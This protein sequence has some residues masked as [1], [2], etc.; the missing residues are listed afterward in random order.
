MVSAKST[1]RNLVH[2]PDK[3]DV[4]ELLVIAHRFFSVQVAIGLVS[5]LAAAW[6]RSIGL[7][8]LGNVSLPLLGWASTRDANPENFRRIRLCAVYWL[9]GL[10]CSLFRGLSSGSAGALLAAALKLVVFGAQWLVLARLWRMLQDR[11]LLKVEFYLNIVVKNK[12]DV[13]RMQLKERRPHIGGLLGKLAN[14]LVS[15]DR[16]SKK[17]AV[18]LEEMIPARMS[19]RAGV[20]ATAAKQFQRGNLIVMLVTVE[21]VDVRRMVQLKRG[22]A[23][24]GWVDFLMT[25][26]T[27]MPL[28]LRVDLEHVLLAQ[29]ARGLLQRLPEEMTRQMQEVGG[30]EV[31]VEAKSKAEE[32]EFLFAAMKLLDEEGSIVQ[33]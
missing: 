30:M 22:E 9:A 13:I 3:L 11:L 12:Q 14:S 33:G 2:H 6:H 15:D 8:T 18:K 25:L 29:V 31:E 32:A 7:D 28:C 19:A 24:V 21:H 5:F 23:K 27:L 26:L 16:F 4:Q 17:I 1:L 20:T 10:L